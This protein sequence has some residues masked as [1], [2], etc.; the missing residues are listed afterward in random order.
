MA[1]VLLV[2]GLVFFLTRNK[3]GN[4]GSETELVNNPTIRSDFHKPPFNYETQVFP[5]RRNIVASHDN[6]VVKGTSNTYFAY[7]PDQHWGIYTF[8]YDK[9]GTWTRRYLFCSG[10]N[11]SSKE[12]KLK[13]YDDDGSYAG[14]MVGK[15][16]KQ[17]GRYTYD[18]LFTNYKGNQASYHITEDVPAGKNDSVNSGG[19]IVYSSAYDGYVV[20]RNCPSLQCAAIGKFPNGPTGATYL[21]EDSGWTQ[22]N[23]NGI[24][25]WVNSTYV[26]R[27]PTKEVTVDVDGNALEGIWTEAA[28]HIT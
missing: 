13:A 21:G 10:W 6:F 20:I 5:T 7:V 27:T 2:G 8:F 12:L 24:I 19:N 22:I 9:H 23:Y 4:M 3:S 17:N 18:C 15:F 16:F 11:S 26:T 14:E 28:I 1:A 25:G